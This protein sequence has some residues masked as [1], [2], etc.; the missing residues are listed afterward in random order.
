MVAGI[1]AIV[2]GKAHRLGMRI[3]RICAWNTSRLAY[4]DSG[5]VLRGRQS[6]KTNG[7]YSVCEFFNGR[8]YHCD[9]NAS[10]NI[11]ARYFVREIVK[12]LPATDEQRIR[13]NVPGCA[14]RI[15]CT[16]ATLISLNSELRASTAESNFPVQT[17]S[18][19]QRVCI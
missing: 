19:G 14:K 9:L 16:L 17:V 3:A 8:V 2:T 4:D 10:Y 15:T 5:P 18:A 1:Q 13:A 6:D 12:S 7:S 11:G